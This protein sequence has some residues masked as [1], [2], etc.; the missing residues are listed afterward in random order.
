MTWTDTARH[1]ATRGREALLDAFELLP[2][3]ICRFDADDRFVA[4]NERFT[5]LLGLD[6]DGIG[7]GVSL[8][9]LLTACGASLAPQHDSRQV[10]MLQL[11]DGRVIEIVRR[12]VGDGG[13]V[14]S[15]HDVTDRDA[16]VGRGRFTAVRDPDPDPDVGPGPDPEL[17]HELRRGLEQDE[18]ELHFQPL[19][20]L[21]TDW[22]TG[23]EALVR[24]NHPEYGRLTPADFMRDAEQSGV[25]GEL[26]AWTLRQACE[27]ALLWPDQLRVSVN[28]SAVQL[29]G[30]IV[31]QVSDA[32]RATGLDSDR[33]EIEVAE[34]S[35]VSD[36]DAAR[37]A[38][39]GLARL[40]VRI[41]LDQFGSEWSA[42]RLLSRFPFSK[43][44]ID[45]ALVAD[46]ECTS[47]SAAMVSAVCSFARSWRV[48][49]AAVGV[50]TFEQLHGVRS[51]GVDEAQ[52]FLFS[53]P[54][55]ARQIPDM[56]GDMANRAPNAGRA[57]SLA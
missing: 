20:D 47:D 39:S 26:G 51:R 3:G 45:R 22:I 35:I 17:E 49:V 9:T 31:S 5:E 33:L 13:W 44:K 19:I 10:D 32:L 52:G 29:A 6:V 14:A 8:T 53:P 30:E 11:A 23:F 50:E 43:V 55:T 54:V 46:S 21:N 34:T 42:L 41:V 15:C 27:Q 25:I 36:T 40:G 57:L 56:V 18:F 37:T 12:A 28:V 7:V 2:N 1:A 38:L 4:A 16:L 24:W 48:E